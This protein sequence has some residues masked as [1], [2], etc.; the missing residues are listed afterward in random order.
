MH[1]F[2]PTAMGSTK[3][4]HLIAYNHFTLSD[5]QLLDLVGGDVRSH[6]LSLSE[7]NESLAILSKARIMRYGTDIKGTLPFEEILWLLWQ[8]LIVG[9][10]C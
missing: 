2:W 7:D 6:C 4:E 9:N 10:I 3:V 5:P 1:I 8:H